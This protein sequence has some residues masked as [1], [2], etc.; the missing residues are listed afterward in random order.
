M[1]VLT[2]IAILILIICMMIGYRR[3]LIRAGFRLLATILSVVLSYFLAPLVGDFIIAH[4]KADDAIQQAIYVRIE[5]IAEEK[6]RQELNTSM[7]ELGIPVTDEMVDAAMRVE[8]NKNQQIELLN[9]MGMSE[10]LRYALIENNHEDAKDTLGI[11]GFYQYIAAYLTRL[12]VRSLSYVGTFLLL[13]LLFMI[14]DII[15]KLMMQI[16]VVSTMNRLAGLV[17]GLGEGILIIWLFLI[18][19]SLI[20]GSD[21]SGGLYR[22][23]TDSPMLLYMQNHNLLQPIAEQM[24]RV[25]F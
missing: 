20:S 1:N 6:V 14:G 23:I 12:V 5:A 16:P 19:V 18:V 13:G 7:G 22:Q 21:A 11:T 4:T 25:I 3:G 15:L 24:T 9:S 8:L 10:S 2:T 17:L